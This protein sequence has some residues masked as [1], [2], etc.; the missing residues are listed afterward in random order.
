MTKRIA[1]R[2]LW[3]VALAV[4]LLG[5]AA[6]APSAQAKAVNITKPVNLAIPDA[7]P[8]APGIYGQL[9]STIQVGK[10]GKASKV[11]DVNVTIQATGAVGETP[12][13]D[14]IFKLTGPNGATSRL[15]AR[16]AS[17][18]AT[19]TALGPLTLDDESP[20]EVGSGDPNDPTQLF[21]PWAGIAQPD[22][23]YLGV[24]D[25]SRAR[26]TWTL[27]ALDAVNG[28]TSVLNSWRLNIVTGK[29][30]A[31]KS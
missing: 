1:G 16:N 24:F 13:S 20:L 8:V 10:R 17:F 29:P 6:F 11:R 28:E 19:N 18:A 25:N 5:T 21:A 15:W 7:S 4:G 23:G 9:P 22:G 2:K 26:G 14:L 31:K 27:K 3:A 30:Y 12:I